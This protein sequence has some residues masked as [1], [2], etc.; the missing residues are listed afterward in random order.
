MSSQRAWS[1]FMV[2]A[3][4]GIIVFAIAAAPN[5]H[6]ATFAKRTVAYAGDGGTGG[7]PVPTYTPP[8]DYVGGYYHYCSAEP[9]WGEQCVDKVVTLDRSGNPLPPS[10]GYVNFEAHCG[11]D[12]NTLALKGTCKYYYH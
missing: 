5:V 10:C 1:Q 8:P 3:V 6:A 2:I 4:I 9:R 11:C 7:L 12:P